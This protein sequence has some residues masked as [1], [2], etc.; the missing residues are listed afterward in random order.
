MKPILI[1]LYGL[2][3]LQNRVQGDQ[4]LSLKGGRQRTKTSYPPLFATAAILPKNHR[5]CHQ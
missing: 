2:T 3:L 4:Y 1:D 5:L